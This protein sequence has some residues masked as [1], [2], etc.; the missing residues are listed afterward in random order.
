MLRVS[1]SWTG[2]VAIQ[3]TL[4]LL[5]HYVL[6]KLGLPQVPSAFSAF[7]TSLEGF[8]P[9]NRDIFST[10]EVEVLHPGKKCW[11]GLSLGAGDSLV[12]IGGVWSRLERHPRGLSWW[13]TQ[14]R[15]SIFLMFFHVVADFEAF[16]GG[17]LC[18]AFAIAVWKSGSNTLI[19]QSCVCQA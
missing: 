5:C 16:Q 8:H 15:F 12:E 2:C 10:V 7:L 11:F 13:Q 14:A 18:H 19:V 6:S 17:P 4:G 1:A 9:R 3:T